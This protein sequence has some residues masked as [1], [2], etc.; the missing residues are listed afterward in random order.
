[1]AKIQNKIFFAGAVYLSLLTVIEFI[2]NPV[3]IFL[4]LYGIISIMYFIFAFKKED[5]GQKT[6]DELK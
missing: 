1:M 5:T 6:L 3:K 2:F 4:I